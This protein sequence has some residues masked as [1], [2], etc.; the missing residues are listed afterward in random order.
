MTVSRH[1]DRFCLCHTSLTKSLL[2]IPTLK[3]R[4]K[5]HSIYCFVRLFA[6]IEALFVPGASWLCRTWVHLPTADPKTINLTYRYAKR[7]YSKSCSSVGLKTFPI[8][9]VLFKTNIVHYSGIAKGYWY[10]KGLLVS[11]RPRILKKIPQTGNKASMPRSIS[12]GTPDEA[13]NLCYT[14]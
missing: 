5:M 2:P 4:N 10:R 14:K 7:T 13:N 8:L 12:N 1:P 9:A 6:V 11:Q 3:E